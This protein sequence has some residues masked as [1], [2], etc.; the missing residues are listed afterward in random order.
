MS[1]HFDIHNTI[2]NI[3]KDIS[4]RFL[5]KDTQGLM[6]GKPLKL[7]LRKKRG[8][9]CRRGERERKSNEGKKKKKKAGK[10]KGNL[11]LEEESECVDECPFFHIGL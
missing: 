4:D 7:Y 1:N 6:V 8:N 2:E 9:Y 10:G 3:G 5:Q 11:T